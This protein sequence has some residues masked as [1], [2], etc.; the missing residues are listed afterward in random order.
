[1]QYVKSTFGVPKINYN[2]LTIYPDSN[3]IFSVPDEILGWVLTQ[4]FYQV[5]QPTQSF[6]GPKVSDPVTIASTYTTVG[7]I[8][9]APISDVTIQLKN[10]G[11]VPLTGFRVSARVTSDSDFTVIKS[12]SFDITDNINYFVTNNPSTLGAGS[13]TILKFLV[14][15]YDA[16]KLEAVWN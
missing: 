8:S 9:T 12:S 6:A 10:T 3:G 5:T 7:T 13:N 14:N 16:I 2:S 15:D 1:M 4:G 11:S